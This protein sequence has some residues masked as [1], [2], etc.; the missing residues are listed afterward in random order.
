[1]LTS[2]TSDTE[3]QTLVF[4]LNQAAI[5]SIR[6]I[7][8]TSQYIFAEGNAWSGAWDWTT[9]NTNLVNL[10]DPSNKL[11]YEMHRTAFSSFH[12]SLPPHFPD[13]TN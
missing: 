4:N 12:P 1:V 9:V 13:P 5:T 11:I 10:T 7:G 3:D 8:A 2:F 6:G